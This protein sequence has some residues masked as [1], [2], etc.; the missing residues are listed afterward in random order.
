MRGS[1]LF[2]ASA[3]RGR[4]PFGRQRHHDDAD[5]GNGLDRLFRGQPNRFGC[6]RLFRLDRNG[7]ENLAIP[8]VDAGQSARVSE[9][10]NAIWPLDGAQCR[11][12][13]VIIEHDPSLR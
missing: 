13:V 6:G 5:A 3:P 7:D 11:V 9:R 12:D 8:D 2:P 1:R 10:R 4:R